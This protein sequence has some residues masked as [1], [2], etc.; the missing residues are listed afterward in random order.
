MIEGSDPLALPSFS[1]L[2][3]GYSGLLCLQVPEYKKKLV[4]MT[5]R[6]FSHREWQRYR[7]KNNARGD[8]GKVVNGITNE[9]SN[10]YD[11]AVKEENVYY[12]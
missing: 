7:D 3:D 8:G 9:G 2:L 5:R 11:L 6:S 1:I 12:E 4:N 10:N